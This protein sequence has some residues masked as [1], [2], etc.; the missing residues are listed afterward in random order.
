MKVTWR[1]KSYKK[2][3][4]L[5][6]WSLGKDRQYTRSDHCGQ[7][8]FDIEDDVERALSTTISPTGR[9]NGSLF[10]DSKHHPAVTFFYNKITEY[11]TRKLECFRVT[12]LP[13][14]RWS[15]RIKNP[16]RIAKGRR[17]WKHFYQISM[18]INPKLMYPHSEKIVIGSYKT[19]TDW[20]YEEQLV[21][22]LSLDEMFV[23]VAGAA[24]Y[25]FVK[26]D[27]QTDEGRLGNPSANVFGLEW[28]KEFSGRDPMVVR[29]KHFHSIDDE[30]WPQ[31]D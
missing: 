7:F 10:S 25:R 14:Q 29:G 31:K 24:T 8:E 13:K 17:Y 2:L 5:H 1:D 9:V 4:V 12:A 30:W 16:Q 20:G 11:D 6:T 18:G 21:E 22:F 27:K 23:F 15:Y 28:L 26:H 3:E 19:Q